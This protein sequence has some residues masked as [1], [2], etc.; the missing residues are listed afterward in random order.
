MS[1]FTKTLRSVGERLQVPEP[2]RS[3]ILLEI[4]ADLEDGYQHHLDQGRDEVEAERLA[5]EAFVAS[6]DAL[7]V[8][9]RIHRAGGAGVADRFSEQ[10]GSRWSRA[11]LAAIL[12]FEL[13][14]A[15]DFVLE[16]SFFV[17]PSPFLW[18]IGLLAFAAVVFTAWKLFQ[19]YSD[20]GRDVR[21]LRTGL[22]L[23]LF[24]GGASMGVAGL[25][26]L[27]HLQRFLMTHADEAPEAL[28]REF[29]GWMISISS[30][31]VAGLLTAI[32]AGLVWF[33]LTMLVARAE[34]SRVENLLQAAA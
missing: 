14:L 18:P 33:V 5:E 6:D 21:V 9:A 8:L 19:I 25:G 28:F 12:G 16:R 1:R 31:M 29:A 22:G 11:L 26:L 30:L 13:L 24:L 23:P 7:Q 32:L 20:A 34:T 2:S 3:R 17:R 10:I 15:L 27:Y 4:A